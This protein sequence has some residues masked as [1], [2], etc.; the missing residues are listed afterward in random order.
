VKH[1]MLTHRSE[2]VAR[3]LRVLVPHLM[4][5]S[6]EGVDVVQQTKDASGTAD[7]PKIT[8]V[9]TLPLLSGAKRR[10]QGLNA[11]T[12]QPPTPPPRT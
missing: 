8:G 9:Q 4:R 3:A 5:V 10:R 6:D 11:P 2:N 7:V 12:P 1:A